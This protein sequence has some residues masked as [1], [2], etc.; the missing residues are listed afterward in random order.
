MLTL[1]R[2]KHD[3]AMQAGIEAGREEAFAV[4]QSRRLYKKGSFNQ[5]PLLFSDS[6]HS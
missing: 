6:L 2:G 5:N 3:M 1:P 4:Y